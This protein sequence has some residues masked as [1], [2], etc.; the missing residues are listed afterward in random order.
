[1]EIGEHIGK[2]I[3][4]EVLHGGMSEVYRVTIDGASIRFV[5]K[6][7]K[8]GANKE[9]RKLFQREMRVLRSLRHIFIIEVLEEHY[10]EDCPYYVMPSCG[11]SLVDTISYEVDKKIELALQF[12]EGIAFMHSKGVRHRD[13]KPQNILIKD[14]IVKIADFGL[15]RFSQRDSTTLTDTSLAAGTQGFIPPEYANGGFKEGTIEGDIYMLGKTIYFL[16]SSGGDVSNVRLNRVPS[17]IATI[18]EKATREN[19]EERYQSIQPIIEALYSYKSALEAIDNLPKSIEDI[20]SSFLPGSELFN[21]ELYKHFNSLSDESV[22]WGESLRSIKKEELIGML[23][24]KKDY[25]YALITHFI[26]CIGNPSDYI[27]FEDIDQFV[28][29]AHC[30]ISINS[31]IAINQQ[32]ISFLLNLSIKYNRWPSMNGIA[33]MLNILISKDP[34]HYRLFVFNQKSQLKEIALHLDSNNKFNEI[35][36]RLIAS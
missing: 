14:G 5:I 17:P 19:P 33:C 25:I 12:C 16:F 9:S 15:S 29:F 28:K 27:Q 6:R 22:K 35:I 32:L 7:L 2:Y 21:E 10:D 23:K 20:R 11:K 3:I 18:V 8:D 24:Y 4:T 34:E 13:I 36:T 30:V 1:M 31:D 26:E